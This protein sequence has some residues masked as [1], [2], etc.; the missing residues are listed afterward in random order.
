MLTVAAILAGG[1]IL[2][3]RA[4]PTFGGMRRGAGESRSSKEG[5]GE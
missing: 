3:T 5:E 2:L 4:A 1:A